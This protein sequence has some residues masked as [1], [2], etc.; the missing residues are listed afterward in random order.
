MAD[1]R[2]LFARPI[3]YTLPGMDQVQVQAGIPY[4]VVDRQALR[5][6]VYSP[7][8][9]AGTPLPAVIYVH[10]E[11]SHEQLQLIRG[12][13]AYTG[14]GRLTAARGLIGVVFN[15]RFS[16]WFTTTD[17]VEDTHDAIAYVREHAAEFGIDAERLAVWT[18]SAGGPTA[19]PWLLRESPPWLR[20]LVAHYSI[21]DLRVAPIYGEPGP[22]EEQAHTMSPAA[23]LA[24]TTNPVPPVL[25]SKAG[26]D[27]PLLNESIDRF[28]NVA[29]ARNVTLDLMTHPSGHHAFD[30][31]DDNARSREIIARTLEF[32]RTQLLRA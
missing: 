8:E 5:L 14:W 3:V 10:G 9:A 25:I 29:L 24:E 17:G 26:L 1:M 12:S 28:V 20:A 18:C 22:G 19:F 23:A 21:L 6:D 7:A 31:L 11:A 16:E 30:V 32:L 13:G 2:E 27:D 4:K 15:H